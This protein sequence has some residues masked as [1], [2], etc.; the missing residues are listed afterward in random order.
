[1][2][3]WRFCRLKC[4]DDDDDEDDGLRMT[5]FAPLVLPTTP[6]LELPLDVLPLRAWSKSDS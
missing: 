3:L 5:G 1:M 4:E 2:M 6:R